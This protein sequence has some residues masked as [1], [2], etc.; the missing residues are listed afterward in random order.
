M[1]FWTSVGRNSPAPE[2]FRDLLG[3]GRVSPPGY[4]PPPSFFREALDAQNLTWFTRN[5]TWLTQ[6]LT[7][8]QPW[9]I[10]C[11]I[12][13]V[14]SPLGT[15]SGGRRGAAAPHLNGTELPCALRRSQLCFPFPGYTFAFSDSCKKGTRAV[16]CARHDA[17]SYFRVSMFPYSPIPL[18]VPFTF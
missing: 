1:D 18:L 10:C 15:H 9:E 2:K 12:F 6:N 7:W 4:P 17:P 11:V 8:F 5:V 14:R 16:A 13:G 3:G